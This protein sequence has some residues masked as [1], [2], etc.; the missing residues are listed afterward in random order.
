MDGAEI[1]GNNCPVPSSIGMGTPFTLS[2]L[3]LELGTDSDKASAGRDKTS[4]GF[5]EHNGRMGC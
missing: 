3:D 4:S 1:L 2:D 5:V